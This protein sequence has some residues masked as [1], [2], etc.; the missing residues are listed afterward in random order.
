MVKHDQT[1]TITI[2]YEEAGILM[3]ALDHALCHQGKPC[4]DELCVLRPIV[5]RLSSTFGFDTSR[6]DRLLKGQ[7][8]H[9]Y[10]AAFTTQRMASTAKAR[11]KKLKGGD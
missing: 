10:K 6:I 7:K 9:V 2:G 5:D 1:A 3:S 4:A 8:V 11:A